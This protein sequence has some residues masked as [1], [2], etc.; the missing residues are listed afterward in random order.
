MNTDTVHLANGPVDEPILALPPLPE[1]TIEEANQAALNILNTQGAFPDQDKLRQSGSA[2]EAQMLQVLNASVLQYVEKLVKKFKGHGS[3]NPF[4]F[5]SQSHAMRFCDAFAESVGYS[6]RFI[7]KRDSNTV[8]I[9]I[10]SATG[11]TAAILG[12]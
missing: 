7:A 2:A 6:N 1:A 5:K 3:K 8:S 11:Q 12:R 10:N 9:Y 4:T